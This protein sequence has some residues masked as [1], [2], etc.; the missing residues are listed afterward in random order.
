M[1]REFIQKYLKD[2]ANLISLSSEIT[3][4]L[5]CVKDVLVTA[6]DNGKKVIIVG[7]GSSSAMASHLSVDLTKNAGIPASISMNLI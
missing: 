1:D 6:S 2:F 5:V 4:D 7:N 3:A